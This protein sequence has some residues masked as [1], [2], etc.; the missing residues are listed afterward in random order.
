[1]PSYLSSGSRRVCY[2]ELVSGLHSDKKRHFCESGSVVARS[3]FQNI[4]QYGAVLT[5]CSDQRAPKVFCS[6][7]V[8][9]CHST[10]KS[11]LQNRFHHLACNMKCRVHGSNST[12]PENAN[13]WPK[14]NGPL[15]T[16]HN[17][18]ITYIYARTDN[19]RNESDFARS[20]PTRR[21]YLLY[22]DVLDNWRESPTGHEFSAE[23]WRKHH[24]DEPSQGGSVRRS[25]RG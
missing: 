21:G 17:R 11:L 18:E 2:A 5:M 19:E 24:S 14:I 25:D 22:G 15:I 9:L 16:A 23:R 3:H 7:F 13:L 1:M 20:A 4:E 10:L 12:R 8:R 6:V